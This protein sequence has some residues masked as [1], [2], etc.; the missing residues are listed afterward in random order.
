MGESSTMLL[1]VIF[2]IYLCFLSI[3]CVYS[4]CPVHTHQSLRALFK[5]LQAEVE[6]NTLSRSSSHP[7][8]CLRNSEEGQVTL[9]RKTPIRHQV[10][11][12]QKWSEERKGSNEKVWYHTSIPP[13]PTSRA[14]ERKQ[15]FIPPP[16]KMRTER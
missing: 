6:P 16:V 11:Y 4:P 2:A 1:K 3:V 14:C 7:G 5:C 13:M 9:F 10:Q 8:F 12:G 15:S